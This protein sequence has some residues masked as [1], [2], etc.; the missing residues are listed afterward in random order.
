MS[1]RTPI[2]ARSLAPADWHDAFAALPL[3]A[4]P[5][6]G[7][8]RFATQHVIASTRRRRA[9]PWAIAAAIACLAALPVLVFMRQPA[10]S[11]ATDAPVVAS[12][13][14]PSLP[15]SAAGNATTTAI[16]DGTGPRVSGTASPA[17][18][19][20]GPST[21]RAPGVALEELHAESARLEA[22]LTEL[23]DDAGSGDGARLA[24][25]ISL[26]TQVS[27]IDAA[28]SGAPLD[29]PALVDLWKQ[30]VETLRELAGVAAEQR[31]NALYGGPA[32]DYALVQVY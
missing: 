5:A 7:W 18:P 27:Y 4:P 26:R 3:E 32:A 30:R 9:L 11:T 20:P 21:A 10:P 8:Q 2:P 13:D 22:L 1:D 23:S 29:E 12:A 28:L 31:W 15:T 14:A 16:V 24:L 17:P 19:P 6:D 25:T